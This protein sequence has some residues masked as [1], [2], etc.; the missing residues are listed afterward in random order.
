[1]YEKLLER[2]GIENMNLLEYTIPQYIR[3]NT[4]KISEKDL[5]NRLTAKKVE[6]KK[7]PYLRHGY[8]VINRDFALSSTEEYLMGYFYI[9]DA[10]SQVPPEVLDPAPG[11]FVLDMCAAPGS[12]TTYISQLMGNKGCVIGL[13]VREDRLT[14]LKNNAERLGVS[15]LILFN[16]DGLYVGDVISRNKKFDKILLDAPCSGNY[17][18]RDYQM[19]TEDDLAKKSVVQKRLLKAASAVLKKDGILVYSTCSIETRENEEVIEWAVQNCGLSV[20]PIPLPVHDG[21]IKETK[22]FFPH[23][24]RTQG[25]FVAKMKKI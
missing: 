24:D 8:E 4:L 25:F 20:L 16:K 11:D 12:K 6:L 10:A 5:L 1:M 19:R 15:N 2:L 23:L 21:L 3:V 22:R 13:D 18:L 9:Q 14:S 7:V 17:A